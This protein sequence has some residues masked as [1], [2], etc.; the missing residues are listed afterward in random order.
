ME[1][2]HYNTLLGHKTTTILFFSEEVVRTPYYPA[3]CQ[4][5]LVVSVCYHNLPTLQTATRHT[6]P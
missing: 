2:I 5:P 3:M 4:S 1:I 6:K